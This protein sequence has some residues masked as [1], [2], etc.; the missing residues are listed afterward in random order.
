MKR[1]L[2]YEIENV[3]IGVYNNILS[4]ELNRTTGLLSGEY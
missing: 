4:I 2:I 1:K 3:R